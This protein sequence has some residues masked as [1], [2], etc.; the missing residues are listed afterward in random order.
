MLAYETFDSQNNQPG[1]LGYVAQDSIVVGSQPASEVMNALASCDTSSGDLACDFGAPRWSPDGQMIVVSRLVPT[2][3]VEGL[4][5]SGS[6][7]LFAADGSSAKM[8]PRQTSD[9]EHPAFLPHGTAIVFDGVAA[10][11]ATANLYEVSTNG[12]GLRQLTHGGGSD[13][14]P[15]ATG[16]VA[17]VRKGNIY[18]RLP[19]GKVSRLT[20]RGGRAPDCAPS[21][22][23]IAFIRNFR[24][25]TAG[26]DG[27]GARRVTKHR[28]NPMSLSYSP[29]GKEI[30]YD[31]TLPDPSANG[32]T[33]D[34]RYVNLK[35]RRVG[36]TLQLAASSFSGDS[37]TTETGS[38]AGFDWQP[39]PPG[40]G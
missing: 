13:P 2:N 12:T 38:S 15:C 29:T 30:A 7:E 31:T 4:G 5:G 32:E 21:S 22:R 25:Y 3:P 36:S 19:D 6:L 40:H 39:V 14:A 10:P 1:P 35:G 18:L 9:D 11:G 37:E 20:T 16:A 17:F 26:T 34:L 27:S 33:I 28:V 24:I 8:L 23:R